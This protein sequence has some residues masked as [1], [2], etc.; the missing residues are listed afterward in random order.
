MTP[1]VTIARLTTAYL[2]CNDQLRSCVTPYLPRSSAQTIRN[3]VRE[4]SAVAKRII[5][6]GPIVGAKLEDETTDRNSRSKE[7]P[8]TENRPKSRTAVQ[9]G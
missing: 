8:T 6:D 9:V 7:T 2:E 4:V 3:P 1:D 5:R